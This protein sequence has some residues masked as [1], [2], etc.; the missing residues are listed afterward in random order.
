MTSIAD[1]LAV[2]R[3]RPGF[4]REAKDAM[5]SGIEKSV[6]ASAVVGAAAA[7]TTSAATTT[8]AKVATWKIGAALSAA[9]A[10]G[11]G[12]GAAAH[13]TFT[14]PK[15][16]IVERPAPPPPPAPRIQ[17]PPI[18]PTATPADLPTVT[19]TAAP[20][21]KPTAS[22]SA[23]PKDPSLARERTLLDMGRTALSRGDT[24]A[25]LSALD[26]HAKE[27]PKS[28]LAQEREVL[29]IQAL[30]SAGRMPEARNR[31]ALFRTAYP[32][33]PLISIV[34]EATQ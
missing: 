2:E 19:A 22:A 13:A 1:L 25:A 33:S 23:A 16:V 18:V 15:T 7:A 34:D 9:L 12:A 32:K 30:A 10:I 27:F 24:S 11:A 29:A 21:A 8:A 17:A 28:Q 4:S 6:A 20:I 3:S 14:E 5:W 26:T 31:A